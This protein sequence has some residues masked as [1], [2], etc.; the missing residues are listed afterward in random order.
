MATLPLVGGGIADPTAATKY[1]TSCV[2]LGE[3]YILLSL[4]NMEAALIVVQQ[5]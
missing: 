4:H 1:V 3:C 5:P 2:I